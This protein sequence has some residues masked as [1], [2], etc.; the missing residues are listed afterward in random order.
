MPFLNGKDDKMKRALVL[1]GGGTKGAYQAGFINQLHH[2]HQKFDYVSGTSI[3][4]LNGALVVQQ[5]YAQLKKLWLNLVQE[6][7]YQGEMPSDFSFEEIIHHH[8]KLTSFIKDKGVDITPFKKTINKYFNEAKFSQSSIDFGLVTVSLPNIEAVYISKEEMIEHGLD[9]L[10]ATAS[11]FPAFPICHLADNRYVDG[12][13]RDNLPINLALK[14][15]ADY[16]LA[17]DISDEINHPYFLHKENI[18]YIRPSFSLKGFMN[19]KKEDILNNYQLGELDCLKYLKQARGLKY[20]FTLGNT[21]K[22]F[23]NYYWEFI[24]LENLLNS[25][26]IFP[27]S[28]LLSTEIYSEI[29][30]NQL[31]EEM[32]NFYILDYLAEVLQINPY[33]IWDLPDLLAIIHEEYQSCLQEE[34]TFDTRFALEQIKEQF[35]TIDNNKIIKTLINMLLYSNRVNFSW[36]IMFNLFT[37]EL[38]A[39]I[40]ILYCLKH[41]VKVEDIYDKSRKI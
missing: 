30:S 5:D 13:Y 32:V 35:S 22:F 20:T 24:N 31:T 18:D 19:F 28:N 27:K 37:K 12:G 38:F 2:H 9:Y 16:I 17:L 10:L 25:S 15:Q 3:G 41:P 23:K 34:I 7:I 36:K 6:D 39:A 4:A 21:P 33:Q 26:L 1:G 14:N 8:H 40:W 11:C 29:R